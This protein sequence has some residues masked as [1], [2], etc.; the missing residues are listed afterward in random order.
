MKDAVLDHIQGVKQ[1]DSLSDALKQLYHVP[2]LVALIAFMLAVRLRALE[3]FQTDG[4]VTFRGNDPWYHF[5]QTNYLLEHFPTTM[6][7]DP[8]TNYP[9]G[10]SVDQFGTL[11]DQIVS[12]FIL[13]TSFGDPSTEYAGLIMLVAAPVFLTAT[14]IPAYLIAAR[15]AG[16]WRALVGITVFALLPGT[17]LR[18]SLVGF[19]DHSAAEVFFQTLGVLGFVTAIAVA[20]QSQPVWELVVDRDFDALRR[21]LFYS[22]GAGVAAA[23]Y[24]WAWPPGV[25]LVGFTGIFCAQNHD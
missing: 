18:Y 14:V 21:P 4:G 22:I 10:T 13:L 5:R 24:M 16:R 2:V 25:L 9:T 19:Y 8:M 15:F 17:V 20:Q 6:P 1:A 3:N 12:G 23:L 11:Y 7:F